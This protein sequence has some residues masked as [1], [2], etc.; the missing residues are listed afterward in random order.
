MTIGREVLRLG[1]DRLAGTGAVPRRLVDLDPEYLGQL[2]GVQVDSMTR[3][4]GSEGTTDRARLA[5]T[6]EGAPATVFVKMAAAAPLTRLFGNV[7]SLGELEIG[8]YRSVRPGLELEAPA[9]LGLAF[10]EPTRR[11]MIVLED[12]EARQCTFADTSTPVDVEHAAA[13]IDTLAVL[14]GS[15]WKSPRLDVAGVGGLGWIRANSEDPVLRLVTRAL[16][17]MARRLVRRDGS[18]VPADGRAILGDYPAIARRLDMGT[19]TVLHGDPHPGNC[20]FPPEGGAGLL[21]WQVIRRGNPLRDV[22]YFLVLGLSTETR[23]R[24]QLELL[25][26]YRDALAAAGGPHLPAD[27]AWSTYRAMAA[28]PYVA[29]TFT[30]GLGGLQGDDIAVTGLRRAIAALDELDTAGRLGVGPT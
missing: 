18:L 8:F 16:P 20:Y 15:F 9:A 1:R 26:R 23:Q 27:E 11:F 30:A 6:G 24:H 10:D 22:T 17:V 13:V 3:L 25:D 21:D 28:Y 12:L 4:G 2:L 14:H 29:S 5:L 7:A 19:H